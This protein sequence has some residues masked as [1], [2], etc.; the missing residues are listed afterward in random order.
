M[1]LGTGNHP[2]TFLALK[3]DLFQEVCNAFR[4]MSHPAP[5]E[6][7]HTEE[8]EQATLQMLTAP[9]H[10]HSNHSQT[11]AG[12]RDPLTQGTAQM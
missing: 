5:V 3:C 4:A 9:P 11:K 1:T 12:L 2:I 8:G 10:P 6:A 7:I